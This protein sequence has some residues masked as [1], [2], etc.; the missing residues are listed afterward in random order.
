MRATVLGDNLVWE[1][2]SE[3]Q[4][5][6]RALMRAE[7]LECLASMSRGI[8]LGTWLGR[9]SLD[10]LIPILLTHNAPSRDHRTAPSSCNVSSVLYWE[11]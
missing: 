5:S 3:P 11:T 6:E 7:D 1:V 8:V 2:K 9:A 10:I 4:K